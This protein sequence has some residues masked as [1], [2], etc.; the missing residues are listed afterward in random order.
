MVRAGLVAVMVAGVALACT[1]GA[2]LLVPLQQDGMVDTVVVEPELA[3]ATQVGATVEFQAFPLDVS[4]N[5]L[6]GITVSWSSSQ[7]DVASVG[8]DGTAITY[9]EGEAV[10]TATVGDETGVA[11]LSVDLPLDPFEPR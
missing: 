5:E 10:I 1:D 4:G 9:S 7:P 8:P 11:V 6:A 2:S 3:R